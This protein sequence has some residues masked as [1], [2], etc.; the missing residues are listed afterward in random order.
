MANL[1]ATFKTIFTP[2]TEHQARNRFLVRAS[3]AVELER[4]QRAWD[5]RKSSIA[6]GDF[7]R[8]SKGP[9]Q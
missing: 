1:L 2:E 6:M 8:Q 3:N 7:P 4:L 9:M 5:D